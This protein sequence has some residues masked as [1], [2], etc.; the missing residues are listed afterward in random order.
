MFKFRI[1]KELSNRYT[2][3]ISFFC[4]KVATTFVGTNWLYEILMMILK[5]N[6]EQINGSKAD[7]MLE[8][9]SV[10]Y[11]DSQPSPRVVNCHF[12]CRCVYILK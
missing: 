10:E 2:N 11:V 8:F 6:S 3:C 1:K 4:L 7:L 12:P 5:K 9:Q